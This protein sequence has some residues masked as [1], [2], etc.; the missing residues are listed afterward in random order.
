MFS[1]LIQA[2]FGSFI[3]ACLKRS[4]TRELTLQQKNTP[5]KRILDKGLHTRRKN[6]VRTFCPARRYWRPTERRC[7]GMWYWSV[8]HQQGSTGNATKK[9]EAFNLNNP[10]NRKR[11]TPVFVCTIYPRDLVLSTPQPLGEDRTV[12]AW[13]HRYGYAGFVLV[14]QAGQ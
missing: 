12:N 10:V 5:L 3:P 1:R 14:F 13:F 6:A 8:K 11:E 4:K 9:H 7:D 2:L